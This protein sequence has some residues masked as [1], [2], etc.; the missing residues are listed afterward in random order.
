M[1]HFKF[2]YMLCHIFKEEKT[3]NDS[4]ALKRLEALFDD[5][6]FT[7]IDAYA[8]SADGSVEVVAGFGTVNECAVYAFSQDITVDGGAVSV[9]QCAKIKKIYDLALKTGCPVIGV[10]D[11]NGVK[12]TEGFEVMNAYGELVKASTSMSGVCPQISIIAG[13]ICSYC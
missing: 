4:K 10:Y 12:L 1:E 2:S 7:E 8:K 11:S 13:Y 9:A 3:V 5:G 6:S